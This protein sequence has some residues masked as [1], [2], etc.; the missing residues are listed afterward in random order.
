[1]TALVIDVIHENLI[2]LREAPKRIPPRPSG[3]RIHISACYRWASR[4]V[5]G[6][7]LETVKIGGTRYTSDEALQRFADALGSMERSARRRPSTKHRRNR[8]QRADALLNQ[9]LGVSAEARNGTAID[10][11]NISV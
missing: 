7:V 6:V 8:L 2:P 5:G 10:K 11:Q 4:G 9:V 1:M 3:K